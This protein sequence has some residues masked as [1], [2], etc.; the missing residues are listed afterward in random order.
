MEILINVI[1]LA[2]LAITALSL[3]FAKDLFASVMFTGIYSLLSAAFFV[4]MDAVDV[5]FTEAAVGA[6]ISTILMLTTITMTGRYENEKRYH[7]KIALIVVVITGIMLIFGTVD[8][9][10]FGADTA[11]AQVHVAPYYIMQSGEDIDIPNIV[12]SVLASY[13]GFDTFG[14]VVVVF[15]ALIGVLGL[16]EFSRKGSELGNRPAP[17]FQHK[18]LRI[19]SKILI[20]AIMLFAL[21]VQFHGEY[22]PGGGFQAGVIFASSIILYAML[23]GVEQARKAVSMPVTKILAALGVLIYGSVGVVS[24]LNG[25]NFLNYSVLAENDITGQHVGIIIIELGVGIT[26]ATAMILIFLTFARRIGKNSEETA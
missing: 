4:L 11:P 20:P 26:V 7:P 12:T 23:F 2:F 25:G 3:A 8:M 14:E 16:L 6:G 10:A 15:T 18:V 24:M 19:V 5:A 21:Y 9:P 22:S 13:R 1:L 17:M